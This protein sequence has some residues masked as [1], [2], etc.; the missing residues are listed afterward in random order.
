MADDYPTF[1]QRYGYEP[2]PE[3]M[4]LEEL[5]DDLR[6]EIWNSAR[7]FLQAIS[8]NYDFPQR[9]QLFIEYVLGKV[10]KV[11]E[12]DIHTSYASV[13]DEFKRILLA[14]NFNRVLELIE[15]TVNEG[16]QK[17]IIVH[18]IAFA[19]RIE[20]VFVKHAAAYQ[21]VLVDIDSGHS[22]FQFLPQSS[23]EQGKATQQALKT[24]HDGGM[25][26][27]ETHLRNAAKKI[28]QRDFAQAV[29]DS[30]HA[31]ESVAR[32][33]DPNANKTLS[34]AL[35]SL[36]KAGAIKHHSLMGAFSQLYGYTNDEQGIRHPLLDKDAPDV[37]IDEAVFMFGACASFSAYLVNKCQKMNPNKK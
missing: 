16:R 18:C 34:P 24:I 30:I 7:R 5:S 3:P 1:S 14:S 17:G 36:Y 31:V 25:K 2:L 12:D 33:I 22:L 11:P 9:T 4:R 28:N 23:E 6:R 21:L 20:E 27:A 26:G 35:K 10:L 29:A 37:D 19:N 13:H 8:V 32:M 15:T